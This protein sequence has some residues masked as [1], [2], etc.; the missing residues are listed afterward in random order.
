MY[1]GIDPGSNESAYVMFDGQKIVEKGI[2]NNHSLLGKFTIWPPAI[3]IIE[4]VDCYGMP[5]GK[6]VFDTVK[7]IGRFLERWGEERTRLIVRREVRMWLC[8][9][10]KAT[11]ANVN[12]TLK[13]RFGGKGTKK[14]PGRLHGIQTHL[15][16]ALAI[17][18][19]Y[20]EKSVLNGERINYE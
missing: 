9:S 18:T 15:W 1:I 16:S 8:N 11:P 2:V 7:W 19:T 13:D 6:D 10:M 20:Y 12:Q 4:D 5:V 14:N 3:L 17:V